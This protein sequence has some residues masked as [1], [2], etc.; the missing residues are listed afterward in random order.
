MKH[1]LVIAEIFAGMIRPVTWELIAAAR[2]IKTLETSG[3]IKIITLSDDPLPL[4]D[5]IAEQTGMDVIGLKIPGCKSYDSDVYK[6]SLSWL[7]KNIE[8]SHILA[9]HTSQGRDYAPGLAIRLKAASIP[10]VNKIKSDDKGL[11]YSRSVLSNNQNMILRPVSGIPVVLTIMP[12]IFKFD[13]PGNRKKGQVDIFDTP[14][15]FESDS[16]GRICHKQIIKKTCENQAL[17]KAD[18]IVS[19][20]RGIGEKENLEKAFQFAKCF[21]SSAV[22]ASRPL[23]DTG[24]IGYEHQV[25]ITGAVVA[26]KLYIACGI[27]GS[28]QHLAG[29][30][31][32]QFVISINSNP[33]API[34]RHSDLCIVED[35]LE[36]IEAFLECRADREC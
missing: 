10:G 15:D 23:V 18:I 36:F 11:I 25:G 1:I 2:R 28:S 20:G 30:K 8:L 26:P 6:K 32:A 7:I 22:G 35:V 16:Q 5:K 19:A 31:D 12:G 34:F 17:K 9:A 33:H 29:M 13:A 3:L 27:S 4:A 24:W 14:F 21:S